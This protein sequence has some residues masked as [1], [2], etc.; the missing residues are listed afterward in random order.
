MKVCSFGGI[1]WYVKD[2]LAKHVFRVQYNQAYISFRLD[3][4]PEYVFIGVYIQPEGGRYF[5][6]NMFADVG[7]CLMECSESGLTP[8]VGG[9]FNCRPGDLRQLGNGNM[10][11]YTE[12]N[13]KTTN[14]HGRTHFRDL[15]S[16]GNVKPVN[17]MKY[18]GMVCDNDFTFIRSNGK[19][20]IDYCL[21]NSNG[22]TKI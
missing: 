13:D 3:F 20:Q 15:C 6:V 22:R 18:H 4:A 7:T 19:S 21:T 2:G 16:T 14:K 10:W 11:A 12:N 1:A 5:S 17:G 8:F 9:D